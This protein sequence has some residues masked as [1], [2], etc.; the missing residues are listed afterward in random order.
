MEIPNINAC[1][2]LAPKAEFKLSELQDSIKCKLTQEQKAI[3]GMVDNGK[4]VSIRCEFVKASIMIELSAA[5]TS[6]G[7]HSFK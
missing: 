4:G 1:A 6:E 2:N 5:W 7:M 3:K